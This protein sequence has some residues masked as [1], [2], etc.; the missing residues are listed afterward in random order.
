M[1][2]KTEE[3]ITREKAAVDAMKNAKASM[4]GALDRI[5]TLESALRS[6]SS[7]IGTLKGFIAPNAYLYPTSST[8]KRCTEVADEAL[9][10]IVKVLS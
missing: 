5:S 6:A 4:S 3:Q 8:P 2:D 10:D 1:T 7:R 9:A